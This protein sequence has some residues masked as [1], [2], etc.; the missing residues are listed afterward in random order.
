MEALY[1][2]NKP[3]AWV[4]IFPDRIELTR[5]MLWAKKTHTILI[6]AVSGLSVLGFGGSIL[7]IEAG[8][9][10]YDVEVGIGAASKIR[11]RILSA[12]P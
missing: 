12:L 10:Y 8:G 6:G 4:A 11:E 1:R 3:G 9:R 2:Y 5:G 7:R